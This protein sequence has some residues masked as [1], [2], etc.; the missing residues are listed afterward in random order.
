[1][2][3]PNEDELVDVVFG[4]KK[5]LRHREIPLEEAV[6]LLFELLFEQEETEK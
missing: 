2:A 6:D 1:M 3:D 5:D 4:F